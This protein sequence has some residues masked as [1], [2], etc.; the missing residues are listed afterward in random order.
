MVKLEQHR[1][2]DTLILEE[3]AEAALN[4]LIGVADEDYEYIPFFNGNFKAR[5]AYMTHGNWDFGSSHGRLVDAIILARA[6][7]GSDYG[8]EIEQHYRRNLLSFFRPDGLNYRRNTFT[9]DIITEHMAEFKESA[10]MIDQRSVLLGLTTWYVATGE[11]RAKQAAD[12]L[13]AALKRIARKERDSWYYPASE[14]TEKGWPSFDAVHTRLAP[15]P[16]AMWEPADWAAVPLPP[17]HRQQGHMNW[18][19]TSPPTLSTARR[20]QR[21]RELQRRLG[22]PQRL[23]TPEWGRWPP[24]R[25]SAI[26][27]GM[28]PS[29]PLSRKVMIGL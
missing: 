17:D 8:F 25:A 21:R 16:A 28:P 9:Q 22:L 26:I 12:K 3:R 15:D 14:W 2:P 29:L 18:R 23:S 5:P 7:T 11:E 6:M 27:R 19:R 10:S 13:C 24:W 1:L 4:A 20:L